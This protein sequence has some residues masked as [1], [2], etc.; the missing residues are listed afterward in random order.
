MRNPLFFCLSLSLAT[1]ASGDAFNRGDWSLA[2]DSD[3]ACRATGSKDG[4][5]VQLERA[6]DSD[7]VSA[8]ITLLLPAEREMPPEF[9]LFQQHDAETPQACGTVAMQRDDNGEAVGTLDSAQTQMLLDALRANHEQVQLS[10]RSSDGNWSLPGVGAA[11][12][13]RK[14]DEY[15]R[16]EVAPVLLNPAKAAKSA[17]KAPAPKQTPR[18]KKKRR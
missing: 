17:E 1:A 2:C 4:V 16:R 3:N 10:D 6:A 13:L 9:T 18:R 5:S 7:S 11:A 8:A 15:Q 12:V 14:M